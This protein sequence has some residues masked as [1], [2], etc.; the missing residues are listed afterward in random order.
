MSG[1]AKEVNIL[2]EHLAGLWRLTACFY[3]TLVLQRFEPSAAPFPAYCEGHFASGP[4]G[5]LFHARFLGPAI[6]TAPQKPM[7]S[8]KVEFAT[9]SSPNPSDI[10]SCL[11]IELTLDVVRHASTRL[12]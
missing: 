11:G 10:D 12:G 7:Y 3:F 6:S 9:L 5:N 8:V 4:Q 1:T 2:G